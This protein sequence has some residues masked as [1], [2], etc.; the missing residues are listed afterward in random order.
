[1]H[2]ATGFQNLIYESKAFPASL[3][4]DMYSYLRD[5]CA[6]EKKEGETDEQFIYKTRK[7]AFG[8]FKEKIWNM[9]EE[10]KTRLGAE[11]EDRFD[12][13]F[14]KLNAGNTLD[15]AKKWVPEGK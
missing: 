4:E 2:L 11:L 8:P 15:V 7:K 14:K 9:P 12:L 3:K 5:K 6:S 13:I 10:N 1:V